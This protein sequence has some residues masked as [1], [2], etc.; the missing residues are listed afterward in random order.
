MNARL[1]VGS[2]V[3]KQMLNTSVIKPLQRLCLQELITAGVCIIM[4]KT[5]A[6]FCAWI[7]ALAK[8]QKQIQNVPGKAGCNTYYKNA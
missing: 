7:S 8:Q 1:R 5:N 6:G 2:E 4:I 3:K